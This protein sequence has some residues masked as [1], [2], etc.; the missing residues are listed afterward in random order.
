MGPLT[1]LGAERLP[2]F[3]ESEYFGDNEERDELNAPNDKFFE[4]SKQEDLIAL[5]STW[6]RQSPH[7]VVMTTEEMEQ[8]IQRRVAAMPDREQRIAIARANEPRY[9]K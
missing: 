9:K 6:L 2:T 7:L 8:E 4:I 1:A 3:F 5:N